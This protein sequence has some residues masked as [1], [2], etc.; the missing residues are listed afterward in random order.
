MNACT[1]ATHYREIN[2]ANFSSKC[3]S[4]RTGK[5]LYK[6]IILFSIS[7]QTEKF[8]L[9]ETGQ[10][11]VFMHNPFIRLSLIYSK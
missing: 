11:I 9:G 8:I 3:S 6:P 1:T 5:W 4:N 2:A 7:A 10:N